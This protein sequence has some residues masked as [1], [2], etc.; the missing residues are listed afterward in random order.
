MKICV[1][2]EMEVEGKKAFPI[3]EDRIIKIVRT[4]KKAVGIAKMNELY[5]CEACQ[6]KHTVRRKAFE[7]SM[8]FASVLAGLIVVVVL[9]MLLLSGKLDVWAV[10]S[11]FI[12]GVFILVLPIF[13]YAP[14]LENVPS[15]Q[16]TM[17]SLSPQPRKE[18]L[19]A[20]SPPQSKSAVSTKS[21]TTVKEI[22]SKRKSR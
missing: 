13:K 20:T 3:R 22:K 7:K 6:D 5:V 10:V 17:Q 21:Q 2:C 15:P 18:M 12:I 14:A 11:A 4:I 9:V 16:P 8:L 1:S 19:A